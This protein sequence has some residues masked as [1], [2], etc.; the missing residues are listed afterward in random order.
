[1]GIQAL[2]YAGLRASLEL[3]TDTPE[4]EPFISGVH[5]RALHLL[6]HIRIYYLVDLR[7][8]NEINRYPEEYYGEQTVN[9]FN[10]NPNVI[11]LWVVD[12]L[13]EEVA[14]FS[15]LIV[16]KSLLENPEKLDMLCF[17]DDI[18]PNKC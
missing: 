7:R 10:I 15:G 8:L 3:L 5:E 14:Y 12:W 18:D 2:F 6:F 11:P 4:N 16:A 17:T 9:R 13:T 1:M